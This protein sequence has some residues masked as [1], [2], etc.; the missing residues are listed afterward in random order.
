[1]PHLA[2]TCAGMDPPGPGQPFQR[3][4]KLTATSQVTGEREG[5]GTAPGMRAAS[6]S[7]LLSYCC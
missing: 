4:G 7:L 3:G 1:M 5:L 6:Y 2:V